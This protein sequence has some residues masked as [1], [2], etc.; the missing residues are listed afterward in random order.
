M[1]PRHTSGHIVGGLL[2]KA[3]LIG[4]IAFGT[5]A[6]AVIGGGVY[7]TLTAT[8]SNTTAQTASSGV[9]SLTMTNNADGFV[10]PITNL[11]PGDVVNR[12]IKLTQGAD[13]DA[14]DLKLSAAAASI[15]KL[16]SDATNG[17]HVTVSQCATEWIA[18]SNTCGT[19]PTTLLAST[20]VNSLLTTAASLISGAVA[21]SSVV[22]LRIAV[23]LPDQTETTINGTAPLD[24]IQGL[25]SS[26]TWTFTDV[27][28]TA[29]TTNS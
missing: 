18:S 29:T 25:S 3:Q 28:R 14:K 23:T 2:T 5:A 10:Q 11:A 16:T 21:K 7:A 6:L 20:S 13:L 17:L 27:Q 15:T 4:A 9:L 12:F 8:S 1:S 24:T 22:Y 19:T 26:L